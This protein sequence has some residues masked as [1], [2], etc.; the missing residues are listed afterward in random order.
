MQRKTLL[1]IGFIFVNLMV[2][3]AQNIKFS[4]ARFKSYL[5]ANDSINTDSNKKEISFLVAKSFN[6]TIDVSGKKN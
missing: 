1:F 6:G 5:L 4:D 3:N 2:T